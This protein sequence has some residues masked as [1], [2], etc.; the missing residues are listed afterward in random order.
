MNQLYDSSILG[1]AGS[2]SNN[3]GSDQLVGTRN[4]REEIVLF[5]EKEKYYR[6]LTPVIPEQML[7]IEEM[8]LYM[9][10]PKGL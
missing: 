5:I 8:I 2:P 9:P 1:N 7:L 3:P 4:L 10:K 6:R